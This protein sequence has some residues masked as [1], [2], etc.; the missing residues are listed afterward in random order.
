MDAPQYISPLDPEVKQWADALDADGR[1]HF[2]EKSALFEHEACMDRGA[3]E[4]LAKQSTLRY[5]E[6]RDTRA[7]RESADQKNQ[8]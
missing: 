3:A 6:R 5:L 2:E 8:K 1:E 4:A 7:I